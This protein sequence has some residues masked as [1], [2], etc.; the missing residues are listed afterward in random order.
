MCRF[1]AQD[2]ELAHALYGDSG[3]KRHGPRS[4]RDLPERT[5]DE[6]A[7]KTCDSGVEAAGPP[8]RELTDA[9]TVH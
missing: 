9:V 5:V 8:D 7:D 4:T 6:E 1:R 2:P 3:V